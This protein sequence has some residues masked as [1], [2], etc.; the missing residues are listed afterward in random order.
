[1]S[2]VGAVVK[3]Y[4]LQVRNI[5]MSDK[6]FK[7]IAGWEPQYWDHCSVEER[8]DLLSGAYSFLME[9]PA[10]TYEDIMEVRKA[11]PEPLEALAEWNF[12]KFY[13]QRMYSMAQNIIEYIRTQSD[14]IEY[15]DNAID[16]GCPFCD[17][18][19]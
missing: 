8:K 16:G 1:V 7:H 19:S 9:E 2:L 13:Q 4:I 18:L 6:P 15:F 5:I 3:I 12:W 14:K 10:K 11:I 17:H